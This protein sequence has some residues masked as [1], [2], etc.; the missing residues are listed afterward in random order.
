MQQQRQSFY[1]FKHK[2]SG[3]WLLEFVGTF[4]DNTVFETFLCDLRA[5]LSQCRDN[6]EKLRLTVDLTNLILPSDLSCIKKL[7][8]FLSE[9]YELRAECCG[10]IIIVTPSQELRILISMVLALQS[11]NAPIEVINCHPKLKKAE[12]SERVATA[13][14]CSP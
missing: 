1:H 2:G 11:S 5:V 9:T 12:T 14:R 3:C 13:P 8:S 6:D 7:I 10:K 4:F